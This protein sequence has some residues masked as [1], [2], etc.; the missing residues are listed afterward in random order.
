[1]LVSPQAAR[2][3]VIALLSLQ[4]T[5]EATIAGA[6]VPGAGK[7]GGASYDVYV[8]G[9]PDF[10]HEHQQLALPGKYIKTV[11][12]RLA[13]QQVLHTARVPRATVQLC[14][15]YVCGVEGWIA[16]QIVFLACTSSHMFFGFACTRASVRVL[17]TF[18]R[19]LMEWLNAQTTVAVPVHDGVCLSFNSMS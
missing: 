4:L 7:D 9:K 12:L 6:S 17:M 10:I 11:F 15:L 14:C 3:L 13:K 16:P 1:M 18:A 19:V 8:H 5:R 2:V